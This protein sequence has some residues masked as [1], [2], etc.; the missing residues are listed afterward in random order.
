M[1]SLRLHTEVDATS[2]RPRETADGLSHGDEDDDFLSS[3]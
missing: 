1:L 2:K 3:Q